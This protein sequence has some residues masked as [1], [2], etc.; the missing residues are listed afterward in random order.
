[1]I[2]ALPAPEDVTVADENAIKNAVDAFDALTEAQQALVPEADQE[3]LA[4]DVLALAAAIVKEAEDQA[5]ADDIEALIDAIAQSEPGD[6]KAAMEAAKDKFN[7]ATDDVKAK[8]DTG[9]KEVLDNAIECYKKDTTFNAGKG[10]YRVLSN[11]DVTYVKPLYPE[12]TYFQVPNDVVCRDGFPFKVVKVSV[13]AFKGCTNVTKIWMG[14]NIVTIGKYAFKGATNLRTL[15]VRTQA[16][17]VTEKI[18]NAFAGMAANRKG[19]VNVQIWEKMLSKYEPMFR[20]AGKLPAKA[21]FTTI[22]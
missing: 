20:G 17:D 19:K 1:M 11:G 9:H 16:I 5:A 2:E 15:I 3:K 18:E 14:K 22:G 12:D 7:N 13:N 21:Y 6:G 8:V 4:A 10:V